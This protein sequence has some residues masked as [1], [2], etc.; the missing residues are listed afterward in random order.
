M[1][2]TGEV[3]KSDA[4]ILYTL[5][6][7]GLG[8]S[9]WMQF[10]ACSPEA[11]ARNA[12]EYSD[13]NLKWLVFDVVK[14]LATSKDVS[15]SFIGQ[16]LSRLPKWACSGT[17]RKLIQAF[18][19]FCSP[20]AE[21]F[22][23]L[24]E[25]AVGVCVTF[26]FN[27]PVVESEEHLFATMSDQVWCNHVL[28][29]RLLHAHFAP[30]VPFGTF[31]DRF[32]DHVDNLTV[33]NAIDIILEDVPSKKHV[34]IVIDEI[35]LGF[36]KHIKEGVNTF[37]GLLLERSRLH[38]LISTLRD[39]EL[40]EVEPTDQ[41]YIPIPLQTFSNDD[42]WEVVRVYY[43][44]NKCS[45]ISEHGTSHVSLFAD[46][47]GSPRILMSLL[48]ALQRVGHLQSSSVVRGLSLSARFHELLDDFPCAFVLCF[49]AALRNSKCKNFKWG[50]QMGWL[51]ASDVND[52]VL[53]S[54]ILLAALPEDKCSIKDVQNI[55]KLCQQ[56]VDNDGRT[57]IAFQKRFRIMLQL[58]IRV[59]GQSISRDESDNEILVPALKLQSLRK[60]LG[61]QTNNLV[62]RGP[63]HRELQ[64]PPEIL[65][66]PT[67][68]DQ[69]PSDNWT[70]GCY[71]EA[72]MENNQGFEGILALQC[73]E[74]ED[75]ML[76]CFENKFT[77]STSTMNNSDLAEKLYLTLNHPNVGK[78][79]EQ[80]LRAGLLCFVFAGWR[81][82]TG[83]RSLF[84]ECGTWNSQFK[85]VGHNKSQ[86]RLNDEEKVFKDFFKQEALVI[87][88]KGDGSIQD[89]FSA[90]FSNRMEYAS[91]LP[92][93]AEQVVSKLKDDAM[94]PRNAASVAGGTSTREK[95]K[96]N[97]DT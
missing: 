93:G 36:P 11:P 92:N 5:A 53:V 14:R 2:E 86:E 17:I 39:Q 89:F 65:N 18:R 94:T 87:M 82:A 66:Y 6:S 46:V 42:V 83:K 71:Y 19:N 69:W 23:N 78:Q 28:A 25:S 3:S 55:L 30:G 50:V 13:A 56:F 77:D 40:K 59:F 73:S 85:A 90:S 81:T 21:D 79:L 16:Q 31:R 24:L 32:S 74:S 20:L 48:H 49:Q 22:V 61:F 7:P 63:S 33:E 29:S 95:R 27:S 37:R 47:A 72:T 75:T 70:A 43:L 62:K 44:T 88:H 8:K 45:W 97:D 15:D 64:V 12:D 10:I 34:V 41:P 51:Q 91:N 9:R 60:I 80:K 52:T 57:G 35:V 26:N 4:P 68:P 54:P 67:P 96:A 76:I 1:L 38:F 58:R 84:G